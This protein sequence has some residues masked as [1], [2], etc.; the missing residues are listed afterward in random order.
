VKR[1]KRGTESGEETEEKEKKK[2]ELRRETL[3]KG[4]DLGNTSKDSCPFRSKALS[5]T[6]KV[7]LKYNSSWHQ[8]TP[9]HP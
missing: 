6:F 9:C 7:L 2:G 5:L 1:E 3:R 4:E 8:Y